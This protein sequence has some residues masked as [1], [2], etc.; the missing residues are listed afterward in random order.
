MLYYLIIYQIWMFG[1]DVTIL[2]GGTETREKDRFLAPGRASEGKPEAPAVAYS[3]L[4]ISG[5]ESLGR[6]AKPSEPDG[7]R[8]ET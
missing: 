1:A 6:E 4:P 8:P 5:A 7:S 2:T 3:I